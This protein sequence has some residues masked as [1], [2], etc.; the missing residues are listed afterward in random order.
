MNRLQ[1]YAGYITKLDMVSNRLK[2][3]HTTWINPKWLKYIYIYIYI[4][5]SL[6]S[7]ELTV[8]LK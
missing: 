1:Q 5:I 7:A 4:Y 8:S 3:D 2:Q 6:Q